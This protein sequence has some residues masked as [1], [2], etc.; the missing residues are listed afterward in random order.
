MQNPGRISIESDDN[1]EICITEM[2]DSSDEDISW[3]DF[4][5]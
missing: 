2:T 4:P 1:N 5:P 3:M